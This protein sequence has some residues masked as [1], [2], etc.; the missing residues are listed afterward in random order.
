MYA[1]TQ[2]TICTI[3][4]MNIFPSKLYSSPFIIPPLLFFLTLFP[5]AF[6][7]RL[8]F[9]E[10]YMTVTDTVHTV[11]L[12]WLRTLSIFTFK[13]I[14]MLHVSLVYFYYWVV[15]HWYMPQFV[16]CVN[17][18]MNIWIVSSLRWIQ[19]KLLWI[20]RY[21]FIRTYTFITLGLIPRGRMVGSCCIGVITQN[22]AKFFIKVLVPF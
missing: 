14:Y 9:L 1:H 10:F 8:H 5:S 21:V 3:K 11:I 12:A 16:C 19:K 18:L 15:L 20:F 4:I 7:H 22:F 2:E 13:F 6:C 17:L